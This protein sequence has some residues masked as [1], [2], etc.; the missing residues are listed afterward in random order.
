MGVTLILLPGLHG[1]GGLFGPLLEQIP[2]EVAVRVV[3][4]PTKQA[5]TKRRLLELME[6]QLAGEREMVLVAESFSGHLALE[7]A[8]RHPERVK[9]VVLCVSFVGP[10]VPRVLCFLAFPFVMV[11]FPIPGV[12]IRT[13]LS[14]FRAPRELVRQVRREVRANRPWVIAWRIL[15]MAWV[16]GRAALR[17]CELPL[18]VIAGGR[19]RLVGRRSVR[20]IQRV[21]PG[22]AV[23]VIDG[24]HLLLQMR[25]GEV[26]REVAEFLESIG[27]RRAGA[28]RSVTP[29]SA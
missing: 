15:Q 8:R 14:G 9:G 20:L 11:R 29:T 10:P 13:F 6:Q 1:T 4:H 17:D 24:P 27:A 23:R 12:A 19:D 2:A 22:V 18:L 5:C 25:P 21:R 16:D 3:A 7:F 28:R 26:W